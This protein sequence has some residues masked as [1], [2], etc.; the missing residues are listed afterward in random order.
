MMQI[1]G[2]RYTT[3]SYLSIHFIDV[4]VTA[5]A[6]YSRRNPHLRPAIAPPSLGTGRR[7]SAGDVERAV[8]GL[9]F[10]VWA[11]AS[12]KKFR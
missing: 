7:A 4:R 1:I 2:A 9:L 10:E 11:V 8:E 6:E 3:A 5:R 12:R